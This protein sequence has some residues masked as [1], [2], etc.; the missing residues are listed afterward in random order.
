LILSGNINL[1]P[2]LLFFAIIGGIMA[3]GFNGLILG[4][5]LLA[6]LYSS[7]EIFQSM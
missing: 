1:H 5:L 7:L 2:L 4:P 6:L 3:F